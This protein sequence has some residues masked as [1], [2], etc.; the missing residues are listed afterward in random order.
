MGLVTVNDSEL[1]TLKYVI[2]TEKPQGFDEESLVGTSQ[3]SGTRGRHCGSSRRSFHSILRMTILTDS[4]FPN[5]VIP[6]ERPTG[7][8]EESRVGTT[9]PS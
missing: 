2:P 7:F 5:P 6:T 1:M 9:Q 3:S 8:D 4:H